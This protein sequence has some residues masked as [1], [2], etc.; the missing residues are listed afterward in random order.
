MEFE[1]IDWSYISTFAGCLA[2]VMAITEVIH[3]V[4]QED[5][6]ADY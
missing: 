6:Y 2:I 5:S 3:R 1:F 4:H